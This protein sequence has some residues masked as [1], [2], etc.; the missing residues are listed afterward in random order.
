MMLL[1]E[2]VGRPLLAADDAVAGRVEDLTVRLGAPHPVVHRVLVRASRS[3]A[4]LLPWAA[5]AEPT[6][7]LARLADGTG[8]AGFEVGA[9]DLPLES[10]ELLLARDVMDTQVIDLEGQRLSRV[11]DVILVRGAGDRPEVAAVDV[12]TGALLRRMGLR[13]LGGRLPRVAVDWQD[14]HLTSS[15]GHVVQLST[16]TAG[17][18]RLDGPGLAELLSRLSTDRATDVMRTVGPERAA[19]AV[20]HSHPVV[21]R[22]LMHA[23]EG[24]RA[25][26]LR[27]R[28]LRTAGWR[29]HRPPARSRRQPPQPGGG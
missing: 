25:E 21:G 27:R 28:F 7:S 16:A 4:Y 11:A 10:D 9:G 19:R 14:L 23:L 26:P 5:L 15:R 3:R 2:L 17:F 18:H 20:R 24:E 12:G 29:A 13:R 6:T 1:S 8:L 22:R